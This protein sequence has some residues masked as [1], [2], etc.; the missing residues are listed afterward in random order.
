MSQ[1]T[2]KDIAK[3]LGVSH[4]AV[5]L[6]LRGAGRISPEMRA[7]IMQTAEE[8]DYSPDTAARALNEIR[9]GRRASGIHSVM[10]W[11]NA[12]PDPKKLRSYKEFDRYWTGAT[13]AAERSGY[14][15][16]EFTVN[17][18]LTLARL[19][20]I[21]DSRGIRGLII[22]PHP[23]AIDW[24]GFEFRRFSFLRIGFS[25]AAMQTYQ[26]CPDQRYN[27][28]LAYLKTKE[29]GYSRV[30]YVTYATGQLSLFLAGYLLAQYRDK[31]KLPPLLLK[32][33]DPDEDLK[34]LKRWI[35]RNKPDAI[36][37]ELAQTPVLLKRAGF[38]I[39]PE[40]GLGVMSVLDGGADAGIDQNAELIGK[41]AA[42]VLVSLISRHETGGS[43]DYRISLIRGKW[44]NG[45]SMPRKVD[46]QVPLD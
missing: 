36:L 42:E 11:F 12:W 31:K 4:V 9:L 1:V 8:L 32:Q 19:D 23:I 10:A 44:V 43:P 37:T 7:K 45:T 18:E 26:V 6:A 5:S 3:K 30:G 25:Q 16:E 22:P 35:D 46:K 14:R 2:L 28:E 15:L 34:V 20:K 24:K 21:L 29:L 17:R 40:I 39:G 13:N 38:Q 27:A 41:A 33:Q